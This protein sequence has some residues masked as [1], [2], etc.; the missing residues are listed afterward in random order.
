MD[1]PV[2]ETHPGYR[3][4][5]IEMEGCKARVFRPILDEAAR[6]KAEK[7]IAKAVS[8]LMADYYRK[9]TQKNE[10]NRV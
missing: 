6:R 9:E 2:S 4:G 8:D 7:R 5:I 3:V 10:H 1:W